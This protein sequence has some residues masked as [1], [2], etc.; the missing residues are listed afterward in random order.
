LPPSSA[1][2]AC[3]PTLLLRPTP[4]ALSLLLPTP[5]NE[6]TPT[7]SCELRLGGAIGGPRL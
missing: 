5:P 2:A 4:A 6:A 3:Q 7:R 1:R